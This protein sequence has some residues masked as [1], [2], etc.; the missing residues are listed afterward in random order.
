AM[1]NS[2]GCGDYAA[3][4]RD[5]HRYIAV[6][7]RAVAQLAVVVVAP[8]PDR[9]IRLNGQA[10]GISAGHGDYAAEARDLHR[11]IAV[12]VRAVAQLA[13]VV[14]A[15][16][17]D[18]AT[19]RLPLS[20]GWRAEKYQRCDYRDTRGYLRFHERFAFHILCLPESLLKGLLFD[21]ATKPARKCHPR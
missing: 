21:K 6:R 14:V 1:V 17:R 5:L 12:H 10:V 19:G 8:A 15:P 7:V 13:G 3:E 18:R 16:A 2:A 4:A 11:Y 20:G 9:P